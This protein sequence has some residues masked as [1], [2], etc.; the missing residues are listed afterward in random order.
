MDIDLVVGPNISA[1]GIGEGRLRVGKDGGLITSDGRAR[2]AEM[3]SRGWVYS[4]MPA[5]LVGANIVAGNVA[6]PAAAA[7]I[8]LGVL[9]PPGSGVNIEIIRGRVAHISGTPGAGVWAW[10]V[11]QQIAANL[12]AANAVARNH[13]GGGVG[14]KAQCYTQVALTGGVVFANARLFP[15]AM[16]AAAIAGTTP[17][18][19]AEDLVDGDIVLEPGFMAVLAPPAVGTTHAVVPSITFAEVPLPG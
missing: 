5:T 18:Q 15:S 9:N 6:P 4:V 17:G 11:A 10:C 1:D 3:A 14:G 2:Y 7:V 12:L 8:L 19:F 16:F 13:R